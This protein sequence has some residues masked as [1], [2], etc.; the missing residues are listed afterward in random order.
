[1]DQAI[2]EKLDRLIANHVADRLRGD[3]MADRLVKVEN[4]L[5]D[6]ESKLDTLIA[7]LVKP[8]AS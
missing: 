1:M 8:N 5:A 3:K 4:R 7:A 2:E 6:V